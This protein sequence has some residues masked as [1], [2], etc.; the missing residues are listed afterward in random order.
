MKLPSMDSPGGVWW[1]AVLWGPARLFGVATAARARA[2]QRGFF[3]T[4]R[5]PVPVVCVGNLTVGGS[6]K[7]PV[8]EWLAERWI[9][10]GRRPAIL[11]RGFG[12]S[13]R[14]P[15]LVP[16]RPGDAP[17]S[18]ESVG[19]EPRWLAG[20]L[21]G[22]PLGI[23]A[24]RARSAE[25]VWEEF[26]PEVLILDD[27]L[28]HHRLHRD[29]NLICLD[30]RLAHGVWGEGRSAPLLP[31]GPWREPPS[32]LVRGDALLL[33]RAERLDPAQRENLRQRLSF[34][35]GPI[36]VAH[37]R[38]R[39]RDGERAVPASEMTGRPVLALS[40]LADPASFEEGLA[41]LGGQVVGERFGDHH[42]F[43]ASEAARAVERARREGRLLIT[44]EKDAQRLP[45]G[46]PA[47]V[48]RLDLEWEDTA[49]T[50]VVDS[51][52]GSNPSAS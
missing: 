23:G 45:P 50:T 26:R 7:T 17:P 27:G 35:S 5:I 4:V 19:D 28:Q 1:R 15:A 8:V 25:R 42:A 9:A 33:T 3:E 36:G 18:V 14:A 2:Y 34:F 32:A 30:A 16:N 51:A 48:A 40:G 47:W 22:V 6:G 20:R 10:A 39:L 44:T 21:P 38:L 49:W 13:A 41:R 52:I 11:S 24:D 46:F 29:R 31:A 12:R 43:S 37:Y